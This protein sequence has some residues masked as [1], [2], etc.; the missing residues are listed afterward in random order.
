MS[1]PIRTPASAA[2]ERILSLTNHLKDSLNPSDDI[3][4]AK[5]SESYKFQGW[6]GRDKDSV[7][8]KMVWEEFEPKTWTENDVDIKITHCGI[9]G[10]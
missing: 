2:T 6:L 7:Q 3:Q 5:M 4:K 10:R 9:C 8:G 1:K